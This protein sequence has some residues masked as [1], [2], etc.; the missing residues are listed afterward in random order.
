MA[1]KRNG[2]TDCR[3]LSGRGDDV[4]VDRMGRSSEVRGRAGGLRPL[5]MGLAASP[6]R[7]RQNTNT[8]VPIAA[9]S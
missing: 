9:N 2:V 7:R 6:T 4:S 5:K 1:T 8:G 3:V